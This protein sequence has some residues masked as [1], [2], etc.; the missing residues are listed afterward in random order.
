[1]PSQLPPCG[2]CGPQWTISFVKHKEGSIYTVSFHGANVTR[3]LWDVEQGCKDLASGQEDPQ[4]NTFEINVNGVS[5]GKAYLKASCPTCEGYCNPFQFDVVHNNTQIGTPTLTSEALNATSIRIAWEYSGAAASDFELEYSTNSDFSGATTVT[6]N[7]ALRSYDLVELQANT[8]YYFRLRARLAAQN[9]D[10]SNTSDSET[11]EEAV[12]NTPTLPRDF[13]FIT[14]TT[15]YF[16]SND[17]IEK[18]RGLATASSEVRWCIR[19]DE[20]EESPGVY[21]I[22]KLAARKA[23][24]DAIYAAKGLNPPVYSVDFWGVRHDGKI[25][26]FIPATDVVVFQ[27]GKRAT[28]K[29]ED[30]VY[31]LGSFSSTAYRERVAACGYSIVNWFNQN[32]PGRFNYTC[33]S[34]GQT[35]EFFNYLWDNPDSPAMYESHGDFS[36]CALSAFRSYCLATY[37]SMTPWGEPSAS[38]TIP[39]ADWS[40]GGWSSISWLIQSGKGKAWAKFTNQEMEATVLAFRNGCKSANSNVNVI[41]FIADYYRVQANGWLVNSPSIFPIVEKLDGLYHSDGDMGFDGDF[42]KKWSSLDSSVPTWGES[43]HYYCELDYVDMYMFRMDEGHWGEPSASAMPSKDAIKKVA[44]AF[45]RKGGRG[46]HFAMSM[47]EAQAQVAAEA[48]LEF[49][50]EVRSGAVTRLDRSNA[51][52]HTFE[53]SPMVFGGQDNLLNFT[54]NTAGSTE[55]N[56]VN[57]KLINNV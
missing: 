18:I 27:N 39:T 10:W 22:Q 42:S 40:G 12:T 16:D 20:Y 15:G 56:V 43:K 14:N 11:N 52:N 24:I 2:P 51:A 46:I 47:N 36:P 55:T 4:T 50:E 54:N 28:G 33:L 48:C 6:L 5:D 49:L 17:F 53:L 32:A 1:M 26:Q 30:R 19:W 41:H 8:Q 25:E 57:I 9:S 23:Q 44:R 35:E 31:G 45:Y 38:A 29:F 3:I 37:G 34:T 13:A 7:K 21:A